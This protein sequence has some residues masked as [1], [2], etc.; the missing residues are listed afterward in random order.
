M[1][2]TSSAPVINFGS[3]DRD[4]F[5]REYWQ[6]KPLLIRGAF[7]NFQSTINP[8]ELA[9][10]AMEEFVESR[11]VFENLNGSPWQLKHGPFSEQDLT[12]LPKSGWSLLVQGVDCFD[13]DTNAIL[14][15]FKFLPNWRLDD[16]MVS[17]APEGGSVGPHFDH[18]DVFLLQGKG[19]RRWNIGEICDKNSKTLKNTELSILEN[20]ESIDEWLLEPGDMLYLPPKIAHWGIAVTESITYS[21]GF[22]SPLTS[23]I[24]DGLVDDILLNLNNDAQFKEHEKLSTFNPREISSSVINDL[25]QLVINT[26]SDKETI[27]S[28]FGRYMTRPRYPEL[29][30]NKENDDNNDKALLTCDELLAIIQAGNISEI[31]QSPG[32]RFSFSTRDGDSCYLFANG[33]EWLVSEFFAELICSGGIIPTSDIDPLLA[34]HDSKGCSANN[35][36]ALHELINLGYLIIPDYGFRETE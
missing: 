33:Q 28:W 24:I 17:L 10:L 25:E 5:L 27:T 6:R 1:K 36:Q 16:I 35:L 11:L 29:F 7:P 21:I 19:S 34:E 3:I 13:D 23:E 30:N 20:F 4:T 15:N 14:N 26:L 31:I 2:N 18:Y 22:R 12:T 8:D 32:S 9:G